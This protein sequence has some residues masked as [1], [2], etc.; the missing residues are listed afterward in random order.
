[1]R[2][3]GGKIRLDVHTILLREELKE[4]PQLF[5]TFPVSHFSKPPSYQRD[6][7]R[8]YHGDELP[9]ALSRSRTLVAPWRC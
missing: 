6:N 3:L 8:E 4:V 5:N 7:G 1:M 2:K 9:K